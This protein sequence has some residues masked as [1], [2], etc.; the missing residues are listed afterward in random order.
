MD[1]FHTYNITHIEQIK[2]KENDVQS[3]E[4]SNGDEEKK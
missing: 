1:Y 2:F 4:E 3:K